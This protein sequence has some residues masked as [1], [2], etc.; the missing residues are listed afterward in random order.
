MFMF[1]TGA[2]N[3]L[4]AAQARQ[5]GIK[6][7]G[8]LPGAG[9][10]SSLSDVGLAKLGRVSIGGM[11]LKDQ[12]FAVQ[13]D[14]D[15]V[16]LEGV[17]SVGLVGYEFA[18]R[19][20]LTVDYARGLLTLTRPDAFRPPAGATPIPFTFDQHV[21]MVK[22]SVDGVEGE[23]EVDTGSRGGLTLMQP[24]AQA[25]GLVAKYH[26]T[27]LATTGY[28][29]GGPS[30]SLLARVGELRIG[31]VSVR[32]PVT[33]L[34]MDKAG[35]AQEARVA[36]NLGSGLLKRFTLTL[37]YGHQLMWLQPNATADQR[38]VFDRSG[39]WI[40][41]AADGAILVADVTQGSAAAKAGLRAGDEIATLDGHA[42]AGL[43]LYDV[44]EMFKRPVGTAFTL[45]VRGRKVRLVLADQV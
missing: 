29:V 19:A 13:D 41:R 24:F 2:V 36:G 28:G 43:K 9:F 10:G 23:F 44:R 15:L 8:T 39:I 26:A 5:L 21:P 33:D 30:R 20:V 1:D 25:H 7:D 17:P 18:K 32:A 34:A 11:E 22:A 27:R 31:P 40:T 38:D 16:T 42:A 4:G 37:D 6:A 35:A 12:V 3:F 45:G 14:S